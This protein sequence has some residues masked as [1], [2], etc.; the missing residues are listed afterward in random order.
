MNLRSKKF[1]I[2]KNPYNKENPNKIK[3]DEKA[4]KTKYFKPLSDE[5]AVKRFNAANVYK[6]KACN[7]NEKQKRIKSLEDI[8]KNADIISKPKKKQ[9]S[10][11]KIFSTKK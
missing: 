5:K 9:Y 11:K 1:D 3:P 4:P 10:I 6:I 8:K 2:P 7:S